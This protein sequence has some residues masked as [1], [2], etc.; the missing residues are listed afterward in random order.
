MP[1]NVIDY[2]IYLHQ[3]RYRAIILHAPPD[4]GMAVTQFCQK[5]CKKSE[6]KYLDVLDLFIQSQ[7]LSQNI[8]S[9]SPEKF[10]ELLIE[11]SKSQTLLV[12]DRVDF[13]LDTWQKYKRQDFYQ[14]LKDQWDSYK[15]QMKSRLIICL[16][17]SQ[18][19][20]QLHLVDSNGK[21]R[22]FLLNDFGDI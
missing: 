12:V 17:T 11:Q 2:M 15:E 1:L 20:S 6:G 18:E 22:I 3:E 19:I 14:L 4:M 8:D 9:F 7:E 10:R 16:Q 13:L 5:A 21:S